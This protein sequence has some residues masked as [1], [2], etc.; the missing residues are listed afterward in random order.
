MLTEVYSI[1]MPLLQTGTEARSNSLG[2]NKH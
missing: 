2:G 1:I